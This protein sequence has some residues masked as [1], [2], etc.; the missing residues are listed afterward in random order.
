MSGFIDFIKE[1]LP[2][3]ESEKEKLESINSFVDNAEFKKIEKLFR[4]DSIDITKYILKTSFVKSKPFPN[5]KITGNTPVSPDDT[6]FIEYVNKRIKDDFRNRTEKQAASKIDFMR[7]IAPNIKGMHFVKKAVALQ[8]F[9]SEPVHIL[10][11]GDPGTGKTEILRSVEEI[12]PVSVFG[13]GSGTSGV[14]LSMSFQAGKPILGMLP[15]ANKG[16]CCIDELN[17][18]KGEDM[19]SLYSAMEKGFIT[20]DK[21]GHHIKQDAEARILATANPTGDKFKSNDVEKLKNQIPFDSAL[22]TRFHLVFLTRKPGL[23]AFIDITKKILSNKKETKIEKDLHFLSEY[24][25]E[26]ENIEVKLSQKLQKNI[27]RF[28]AELKKSE[29]QFLFEISPRTVIGF[30]RLCKAS[31][32]MNFRDHVIDDDIENVK[33]IFV[34][35]LNNEN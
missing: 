11:L 3:T 32:R 2:F 7:Y 6:K 16:I 27:T 24:I 14:G 17:L 9:A 28:I 25:K 29:E 18:L 34:K 31:A 8:L 33:E 12:H 13:L 20:Y 15:R 30:M 35:A 22:L 1:K 23:D 4:L 5:I 21:G 19:A 10:L 26:A